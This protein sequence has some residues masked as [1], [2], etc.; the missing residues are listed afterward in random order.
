[1]ND[2]KNRGKQ[3]PETVASQWGEYVRRN[4]P[5]KTRA[6]IEEQLSNSLPPIKI[7]KVCQKSKERALHILILQARGIKAGGQGD[8][9]SGNTKIDAE[10]MFLSEVEAAGNV[11]VVRGLLPF[12]RSL[13]ESEGYYRTEIKRRWIKSFNSKKQ[14]RYKLE[15]QKLD[16][17]LNRFLIRLGKALS[18][19]KNRRQLPD[20][21]ERSVNQTLRYIVEG[22]SQRIVVDGEKWP[23]LC[24]L[25]TNA[26]AEFL[27]LCKPRRWTI[28]PGTQLPQNPR[29]LE[30]SIQRLGL[31]RI[32]KGRLKEVEKR[33]G[34]FYF[35]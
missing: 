22:W 10:Q 33:N 18:S 2:K 19:E 9:H 35:R 15:I 31:V 23:P 11:L 26:L 25:S 12:L 6:M 13:W 3:P 27:T 8:A 32:P 20:W 7:P 16:V 29:A 14:T 1:M 4:P 17:R 34:Q 30:R 24:C 5:M 28:I 21:S